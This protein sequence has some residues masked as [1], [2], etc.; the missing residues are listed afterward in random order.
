MD[1]PERYP[2]NP[3]ASLVFFVINSISLF[4]RLFFFLDDEDQLGREVGGQ[5]RFTRSVKIIKDLAATRARL[6]LSHQQEH[7]LNVLHLFGLEGRDGQ[8][9]DPKIALA[10]LLYFYSP[11][12]CPRLSV[13]AFSFFPFLLSC[14]DPV[15][16]PEDSGHPGSAVTSF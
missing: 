6:S 13:S 3:V 10:W 14:W 11:D 2:S 16:L 15:L 12:A 4:L 1:Y 8:A 7:V 5:H 9:E